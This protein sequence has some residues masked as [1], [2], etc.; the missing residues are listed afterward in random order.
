MKS[1]DFIIEKLVEKHS[2]DNYE[3]LNKYVSF[4]I[5]YKL[6]NSSYSEKHHILPRS[7]FPEFENELWNIIEL[8]YHDHR[9]VHLW[10]YK[11]VNIRSY[12]RP[13][14]WMISDYKNSEEMSNA[15]KKGWIKLKNDEAK[16]REFCTKRSIHMK[17]LSSDEQSRRAKLFWDNISDE[18]YLDFCNISKKYWTDENKLQK[19]KDMIEFYSQESEVEKKRL[20]TKQRWDSLN[21]ED[22]VKFKEKMNLINKDEHKRKDAGIKIK[23]LWKDPDYLEKMKNRKPKSGLKIKLIDTYGSEEIFNSM[24][25]I[26]KKYKLSTHLIRKYRD[27][28]MCIL[29]KHLNIDN[30]ILLNFKIK[31]IN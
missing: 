21:E 27:K 26:T 8:D 29:E 3:F 24:E 28:D 15:S 7:T 10:I 1:Y 30:I 23:N 6:S 17:K 22:R 14:N 18:E 4:L 19:S 11:A 12:Q 2:I 31:T 16:Y 25:D 20:E 13:L 5:N 9:L